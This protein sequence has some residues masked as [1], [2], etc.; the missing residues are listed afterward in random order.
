MS[1]HMRGPGENTPDPA[2]GTENGA[3]T[4]AKTADWSAYSI[5]VKDIVLLLLLGVLMTGVAYIVY[6]SL[7]VRIPSNSVA[8]FSYADPVVA[9]LISVFFLGQR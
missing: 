6:F 7:I 5:G 3:S 8:F 4:S 2:E 1:S 9:V